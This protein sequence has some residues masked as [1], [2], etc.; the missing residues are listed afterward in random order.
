[1]IGESNVFGVK[2]RSESELWN[3]RLGAL[4]RRHGYGEWEILNAGTPLYN[5]NQHLAYWR[6][7][8]AA[9]KPDIVIVGLGFN[10]IS[11][12][13]M[14]GAKWSP[15]AVWPREF[16]YALERK[17]PRWQA[18]LCNFC[19]WFFCRRR[20][21]DRKSFPRWDENLPWDEC[22][23]QVRRNYREIKRLATAQ[24]ARTAALLPVYAYLPEPGPAAARAL[25]AIQNN[26]RNFIED[27]RVEWDCKMM[28]E[29]RM[30]ADEYGMPLIDLQLEF[31][32]NPRYY[33]LF[34]D[35]VHYNDAGMRL[36]A[37]TIFRRFE[38]L[39]WWG[40]ADYHC[41]N[42]RQPEDRDE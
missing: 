37:R 11:Q 19:F 4:L 22:R 15:E 9:V 18:F 38:E 8:M 13:W 2:L 6:E 34:V 40:K 27:G 32:A 35:L 33:E 39:G 5:S 23:G 29:I 12:A 16:V 26:W 20:L 42:D 3:A 36:M 25:D 14:M 41:R 10:D 28:D 1:V 7:M 31:Q 30:L 24:G 17:S 21:S